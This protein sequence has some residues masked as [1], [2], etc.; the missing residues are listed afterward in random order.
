MAEIV[1]ATPGSIDEDQETAARLM[2]GL[3]SLDAANIACMAVRMEALKEVKAD[4][5]RALP[6]LQQEA[7]RAQALVSASAREPLF[8]PQTKMVLHTCKQLPLDSDFI[9][10]CITRDTSLAQC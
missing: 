10:T 5:D 4:C 9:L 3:C 8:A 2:H 1:L 7:A 6:L